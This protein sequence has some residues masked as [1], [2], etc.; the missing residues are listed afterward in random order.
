[1]HSR[2]LAVQFGRVELALALGVGLLLLGAAWASYRRAAF[3]AGWEWAGLVLALLLT[4]QLAR[5]EREQQ[6]VFAVL[7]AT[8]V[9]MAV[10]G[11]YQSAYELPRQRA[12]IGEDG[13]AR[14][15]RQRF[16]RRLEAPDAAEADLLGR[17]LAEARA[18]GPYLY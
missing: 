10:Q 8:G 18:H 16:A 5:S 7:L 13:A 3:L 6:G 14:A 4:R 11:A 2:Q 17:R 9:A 12:D 15:V 1:M